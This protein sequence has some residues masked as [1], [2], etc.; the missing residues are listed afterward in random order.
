[1]PWGADAAWWRDY[2]RRLREG[3]VPIKCRRMNYD[4]AQAARRAAKDGASTAAL[5]ISYGCSANTIRHIL[6]DRTWYKPPHIARERLPR[7][8]AV[9]RLKGSAPPYKFGYMGPQYNGRT[10]PVL[11]TSSR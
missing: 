10:F 1:M 2:R 3:T 5:A 7:E 9:P 11:A 4:K 8:S 6:A